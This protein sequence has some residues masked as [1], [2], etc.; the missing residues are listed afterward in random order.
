MICLQMFYYFLFFSSSILFIA[1]PTCATHRLSSFTH[2]LYVCVCVFLCNILVS[3]KGGQ[4]SSSDNY[5][6]TVN[7]LFSCLF[8]FC[9]FYVYIFYYILF[10]IYSSF[11]FHHVNHVIMYSVQV[12]WDH[13]Y[14][15]S[16]ASNPFSTNLRCVMPK[17][18]HIDFYQNL[19]DETWS[20]GRIRA[21]WF[22]SVR[23]SSS[24]RWA[25]YSTVRSPPEQVKEL[26]VCVRNRVRLVDAIISIWNH[27][28][29]DLIRCSLGRK[30]VN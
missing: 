2:S 28:I 6:R 8:L 27:K 26:C 18:S 7:L 16:E 10:S 25:Q 12:P 24:S 19:P 15:L 4:V 29:L 17:C 9:T 30:W 5:I 13:F 22:W 23:F 21:R 3:Y 11:V 1:L 20:P 14:I